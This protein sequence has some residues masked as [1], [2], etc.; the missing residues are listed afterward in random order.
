MP[1]SS[2]DPDARARWRATAFVFH[3]MT[4]EGVQVNATYT[5]HIIQHTFDCTIRICI[6][7]SSLLCTLFQ[8]KLGTAVGARRGG[9]GILYTATA[10]YSTGIQIVSIVAR[11]T[12][13]YTNID[14]LPI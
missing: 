13:V 6:I 11:I 4:R 14:R 1:M 10:V 12:Y 2:R 3:K 9:G 7:S 5:V 8:C